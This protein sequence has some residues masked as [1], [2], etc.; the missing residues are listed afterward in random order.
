[1]KRTIS[2]GFTLIELL[3]VIAII[4]VLAGMIIPNVLG[5]FNTAKRSKTVAFFKGM[6]NAIEAYYAEYGMVPLFQNSAASTTPIT[7]LYS[8]PTGVIETLTGRP[9]GTGSYGTTAARI[10]PRQK[11]F[12][13]FDLSSVLD[14]NG[15]QNYASGSIVD[16]FGNIQIAYAADVNDDGVITPGDITGTS[17][18]R[19]MSPG[20]SSFGSALNVPSA[21]ATA[22]NRR[23]VFFSAGRGINSE[24]II[25]S[26]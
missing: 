2:K 11:Q 23:A 15:N 25:T 8:N 5:G 6:E 1:M 24:D 10:N 3:V 26:W 16:A 13:T 17:V 7:Y 4:G 22:V 20:S 9:R 12:F 14:T 19:S 18:A 21:R